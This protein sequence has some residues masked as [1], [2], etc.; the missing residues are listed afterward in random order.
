M[1]NR[2]LTP[3]QLSVLRQKVVQAV[4]NKGCKQ[5]EVSRL[6][7]LSANS[8]SKYIRAY[9][10]E[11]EESLRYKKRGIPRNYGVLISESIEAEMKSKIEHYTPD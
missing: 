2:R 7:G 3:S 5:S 6:F 8:V 11:G 10:Q 1:D 4:I 9:R